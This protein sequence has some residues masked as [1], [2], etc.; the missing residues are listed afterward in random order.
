MWNFKREHALILLSDVEKF[1]S[2]RLLLYLA[3]SHLVDTEIFIS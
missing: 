1:E 3:Q 2:T